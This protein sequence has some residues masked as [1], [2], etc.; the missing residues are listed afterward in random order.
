M[1]RKSL[2]YTI[3]IVLFA[4]LWSCEQDAVKPALDPDAGA[5]FSNIEN[6]GYVVTLSAQAAPEGQTGTWRIYMGE[7]GRFDDVNDPH[8]N[9]YGE[10]G[11]NYLLGWELSRGNE[12][13]ASTIDVSFKA[14]VPV[15]KTSVVDT[16]FNNISLHLNAQAPKYGATGRWEI[17]DGTGGRIEKADTHQAH[18]IGEERQQY[19]V[20]WIQSYGSKEESLDLTFTTDV[21]KAQAG[22]DELDIISSGDSKFFTLE[23]FLPAGATGQWELLKGQEGS[24]HNSDNANSLFG[25][26]ADTTYTLKWTVELDGQISMDTVDVRFRGKWGVWIDERDKQT[27][28]FATVNGL[29][30][31]AENYN[32]AF[33]AGVGSLYYGYADRAVVKSGHPVEKEGDRKLYGR[34]YSWEAAY[35]GA[36]EGWRLP[37]PQEWEDM[38]IALGGL[39]YADPKVKPGGET[40][41]DLNYGGYFER[42][43]SQD[44]AYRNVFNSQDQIGYFWTSSI[45][46]NTYLADCYVVQEAG[47][48]PGT[49]IV[50]GSRYSLSVRYVRELTK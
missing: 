11:E 30:W 3:A 34:L 36:P 32:Y 46:E 20:R 43:S 38:L 42:Y 40:G 39:L 25:G 13:E 14:M 35:Y 1:I 15:I 45:D 16:V 7:N 23:A 17:I 22:E 50:N 5:G 29:E 31:M 10:P 47:D 27:Y 49:V 8:T 24:V 33:D 28:R 2:Y 44:S 9:F 41:L 4:L 26:V 12:Y 48:L 19:T 18:F 21:L 6:D 37:T